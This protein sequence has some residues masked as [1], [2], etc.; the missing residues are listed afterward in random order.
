VSRIYDAMRRGEA[1][2]ASRR[3]LVMTVPRGTPLVDRA[4]EGYQR[5]LH[6]IQGHQGAS[7]G[8]AILI[9]SAVHGEGTST[10]AREL[11]AMLK[12][13]GVSRVVL[14]D[15]N[16]RTPSQHRAFGVEVGGGLT[17]VVTQGMP[18]ET[19]VRNGNSSPVPLLTC[20]RPTGH[21]NAV[22]ASPAL[23]TAMDALREK[24]DWVIVDGSPATIYSDAGIL[25]PLMDGVVLVVQAEKTRWPVAEQAKRALQEAGAPL[26]GAVLS[27]RRYHIPQALYNRL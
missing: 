2:E 17:E 26:L 9:V 18:L 22:L 24:F 20:G 6:A 25:A 23:R 14:V 10:V 3:A 4:A 8:R 15:A 16:L 1:I 27:R 11:A 19:A 5:I 12:R 13:E 7:Q 21:P